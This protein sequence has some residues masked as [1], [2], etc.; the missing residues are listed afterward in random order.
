M[1]V[2]GASDIYTI[3]IRGWHTQLQGQL[4]SQHASKGSKCLRVQLAD[5]KGGKSKREGM[6]L[7]E[8]GK[9]AA[10]YQNTSLGDYF[11]FYV[12]FHHYTKNV[13]T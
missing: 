13:H 8:D 11:E 2:T 10:E 6:A 1:L 4:Y 9:R 3:A 12:A 5:W 7:Y